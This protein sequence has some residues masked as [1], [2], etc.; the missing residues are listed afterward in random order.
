LALQASWKLAE[1]EGKQIEG[2]K[3]VSRQ[4]RKQRL[5]LWAASR[6]PDPSLTA[7]VP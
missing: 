2:L 5:S 6:G 1:Q 3:Q 7:N 4:F